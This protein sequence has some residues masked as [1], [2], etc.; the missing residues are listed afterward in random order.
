MAV[1]V[2][3]VDH[4][5]MILSVAVDA[6][7]YRESGVMSTETQNAEGRRS[8]TA[9][10]TMSEGKID[11]ALCEK[12]SSLFD[13]TRHILLKTKVKRWRRKNRLSVR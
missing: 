4:N 5:G 2:F 6:A 8:M 3:T 12:L 13:I 11:T 10:R 1:G 7:V 9:A